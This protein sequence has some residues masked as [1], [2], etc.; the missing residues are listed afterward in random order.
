MAMLLV[1]SV[2]ATVQ[3]Q[4]KV[5]SV[6]LFWLVPVEKRLQPQLLRLDGRGIA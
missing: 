6:L 4:T 3:G 5:S 1:D 2:A